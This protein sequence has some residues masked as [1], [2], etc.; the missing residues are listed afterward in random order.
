MVEKDSNIRKSM[1]LPVLSLEELHLLFDMP[2]T[3]EDK[4]LDRDD[5]DELI[6]ASVFEQR[7]LKDIKNIHLASKTR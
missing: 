5:I 2:L 7:R 6:A 3:T 1:G 4:T